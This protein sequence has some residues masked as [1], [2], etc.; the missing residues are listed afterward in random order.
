[1]IYFIIILTCSHC[2]SAQNDLTGYYIKIVNEEYAVLQNTYYRNPE[3]Y[4]D[5]IEYFPKR[6]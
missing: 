5:V 6:I 1:M 4:F 2:L 3:L